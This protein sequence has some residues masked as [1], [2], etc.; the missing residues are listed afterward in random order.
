M[1]AYRPDTRQ[2]SLAVLL[3]H[4]ENQ[5]RSSLQPALEEAG[6]SLDHWRILS[7]LH[8]DPGLPMTS[9]AERAVVP[10]ATLT[11]HVDLLVERG[12]IVRRIDA[13]DK[14]RV[15]A[16]LSPRGEDVVI[17]LQEAERAVEQAVISDLLRRAGLSPAL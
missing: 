3:R 1:D 10:N 14:R 9:I 17:P 4:A 2:L 13:A 5:V 11:R 12:L 15:V 7:V 16:A 6:L 8:G